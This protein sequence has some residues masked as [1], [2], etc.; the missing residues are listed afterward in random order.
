MPDGLEKE[1]GPQDMAHLLGYLRETLRGDG[2]RLLLFGGDAAFARLLAE[3]DGKAV[4][5]SDDLFAG[6]PSL[7]VSPPQRFS[8]RLPGW[9]YKI[10][11]KPGPG[12]YRYLRFA[13]KAPAASGVMLELADNGAWPVAADARRRFYSGANTTAWKA[14]RVAE[15]VPRDWVVVTRDLWKEFGAMRLTGLA[16][17]AMGGDAFFARIEL[18]AT[19]SQPSQ[20]KR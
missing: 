11:E 13:W 4:V 17:T 14:V 19:D 9:D 16:P 1:I 12:E 7:R 2:R 15:Q 20:T 3:G 10:V 6:Q 18:L 8:S 5:T